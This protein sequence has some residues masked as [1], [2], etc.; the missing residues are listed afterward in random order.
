M[1]DLGDELGDRE[2]DGLPKVEADPLSTILESDESALAEAVRR[3][4]KSSRQVRNYAA[5]GNA[6]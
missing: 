1:P 2:A 3:L 4:V 5:F 6:P